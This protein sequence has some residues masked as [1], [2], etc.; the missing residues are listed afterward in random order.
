MSDKTI[1]CVDCQHRF[2]FSNAEQE[3]FNSKVPPWPAPKRC[4]GCRTKRREA[5]FAALRGVERNARQVFEIVCAKCGVKDTVP[6][7]PK[8]NKPTYCRGCWPAVRG[9]R[10]V[11]SGR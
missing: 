8:V 7:P 4:I 3:I 5:K 6:F 2:L 1:T 11:R 10:P 9:A